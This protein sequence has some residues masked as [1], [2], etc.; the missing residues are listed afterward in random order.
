MS[1]TK[2]ALAWYLTVSKILLVEDDEQLAKVVC[3]WLAEENHTVEWTMDGKEGQ[4]RLRLYDY[5]LAIL[6]IGLPNVSGLEILKD[7]RDKNGQTP[8]LMLTGKGSV[9]DKA[10]GLDAGADDYL[11]KPFHGLELAARMRAILRRPRAYIGNTVSFADLSLDRDGFVFKRGDTQIDLLPKE[12]DLMEFLMKNPN[13][14]FTQE[15]LL[16]R[17]WS[18]ESDATTDALTTVVKRLRKKIDVPSKDSYIR[19]VH[20][21]GYRLQIPHD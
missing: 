17:V 9:E 15:A 18:S 21:V 14:V 12:F 7:H 16:N 11:T 2:L 1:T 5:D 13:R 8:I 19:T 6:D 20:G 10:R 3:D 4:D